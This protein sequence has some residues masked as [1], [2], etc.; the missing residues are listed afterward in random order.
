[1]SDLLDIRRS[2]ADRRGRSVWSC[3]CSGRPGSSATA[4]SRP[5]AAPASGRSWPGS[6]TPTASSSPPTGSSRTCGARTRPAPRS[7]PSTATSRCCA[8][9]SATPTC[10]AG[11]VRATC[12]TCPPDRWTPRRSSCS[13]AGP[14]TRSP[15]TRPSPATPPSGRSRSGAGPAYADVADT[16]WGRAA[17]VHLDELRLV[18]MQVRFDALIELGRHDDVIAELDRAVDDHPMHERFTAQ[19]ML[20]PLPLA[21]GRSRRCGPSTAPG[22]ASSRSSASSPAP[23]CCGSSRRSSATTTGSSAPDRRGRPPRRTASP[24]PPRRRRRA[25]PARRRRR[26]CGS[27]APR[28]A[29]AT[30]RS[31]GGRPSSAALREAWAAARAGQR[32]M[33]IVTGDAGAGKTRLVSRFVEEAH[34][35]GAIVMWGRATTEAIV[36]Y[37]P[38]VEGL[39]AVLRSVSPEA[40]HRVVEG[41]DALALL[42]PDL[43]EIV[44]GVQVVR[45]EVGTERYVLFETVADLLEAESAVWPLVFVLDDLHLTDELSLRLLDH[46][47]RHERPAHVLLVAT[48]RTGPQT[49]SPHLEEF[50]ANLHRD[51]FLDRL[52]VGG[53]EPGDVAEL[54][55]AG[56]W[57]GGP[58]AQAIHRATGGN[59]FFVTELAHHGAAPDEAL[60]DSIRTVLDARLDRLDDQT[61][62]PRRAGRGRRARRR[63][64]GARPRRRLLGRRGAR[65]RRRRHRRGRAHRGRTH[66]VGHLPARARAAGRAR[67][68]QPVPARR[69]PPRHRRRPRRVGRRDPRRARPPPAQRRPARAAR[70]R[71][72]GRARRRARRARRARLRGR[73]PVGAAGHRGRGLGRRRR[74]CGARRCCCA[75]TR[76]GRS[77]TASTRVRRRPRRPTSPERVVRPA[78]PRPGGRRRS[79]SPGPGSASTS[80]PRTR[81]STRCSRRR[82]A[83]CPPTRRATGPDC[84]SASMSNAAADGDTAKMDRLGHLIEHLPDAETHPVLVA[85]VHLARRMAEWRLTPSTSGWPTTGPPPTRPAGPA[86][87]RS[88][89]TRCCTASPTSPR[90][91]SISEAAEWFERF[92]ARAADVRQPVYDAFVLF[93]DATLT[94]LQGD[95]EESTR[96]VDAGARAR[97]QEPRAQRR[98]GVGGPHVRAGLGPGPPGRRCTPCSRAWR[99]PG[100]LPIWDIARAATG[101]AAGEPDGG[102]RH[103]RPRSSTTRCTSATTRC[104]SPRWR[105]LVE[106]ARALGDIERCEVLLRELTPYEGR[107]GHQRA[108]PGQHRPGRPLRPG[109]PRSS[110]VSY[111][112]GRRAV[113]PRRR[114]SAASW[115][116]SRILARNHHDWAAVKSALGDEA[117]AMRLADRARELADRVGMVARRPHRHRAPPRTEGGDTHDRAL[118]RDRRRRRDL[119]RRRRVPTADRVPRRSAT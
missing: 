3:A 8:G 79:R 92:R 38:I 81:A 41:R 7:A 102:A 9:R 69:A 96:L 95:Y 46:V 82:S 100:G 103:V 54:L 26:P 58:G 104:G 17:A 11:T 111:E 68:A 105:L 57:D 55:A 37:E 10:S 40:Q 86:T 75:R 91:G 99:D 1:M 49:S 59:P 27:P 83:R 30:G 6:C 74:R 94:L 31:S 89:S 16:E 113:R 110:P 78:A 5:S 117:A 24:R 29:T 39:R 34:R 36:P 87:R 65:L 35:E 119:R 84:S 22:S 88:S 108:R 93:I 67:A 112:R 12:S 101:I 106:V 51:G 118:R 71:G 61:D 115:R 64:P 20:E 25:A 2:G 48:A 73:R 18:A 23:S 62:A 52:T 97:P 70:H 4:T 116:R 50:C 114:S 90:P 77:A 15:P 107:I 19:L 109:S 44:P 85:T 33:V 98:A 14:A 66:R 80:A 32:R 56:G 43:A 13:P 21:A 72:P 47:L 45:P 63:H 42:V 60:P 53:L 28:C 76:S